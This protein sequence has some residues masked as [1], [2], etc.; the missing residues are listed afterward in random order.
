MKNVVIRSLSGIIYIAIIVGCILLGRNWFFGLTEALIVLGISEYSRLKIFPD[1]STSAESS[2]NVLYLLLALICG[3]S[4]CFLCYSI[5]SVCLESTIIGG[6]LTVA[7]L[8]GLLFMG[9]VNNSPGA[10]KQTLGTCFGLLYIATPLSLLNLVYSSGCTNPGWLLI[11]VSLICIWV[12]DTGAFCVG[13]TLGR[14]R[15]C[16]RLSPKKSWEGFWGGLILVV[17]GMA[18][19]AVIA[20]LNIA[21]YAAYGIVIAVF[22]TVGDLFESLLK[23]TA[24][25]KDSG[26]L[27]PGHGGILDRID[28]LLFVSYAILLMWMLE[29]V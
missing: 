23:R 20:E 9:V 25:V 6:L 27:I 22:A 28:S 3:V 14:H 16:V 11:L 24:G 15:L 8:C 19:Y 18:V 2:F 26:N 7:A 12:N 1:G 17:I 29:N 4:L 21:V 10:L 5:K 13:C